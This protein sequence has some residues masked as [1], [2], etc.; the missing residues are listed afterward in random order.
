MSNNLPKADLVA[1]VA[2]DAGVSK[3]QAQAV[4]DALGPVVSANAA[5]GY[6]ITLPGLGRFTEKVRAARTGRNPATGVPVEIPESRVLTFKPS[7]SA[8]S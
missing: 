5:N 8:K 3:T 4:L 6:T 2:A 1:F 7:K